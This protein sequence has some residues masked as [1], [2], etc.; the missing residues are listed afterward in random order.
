MGDILYLGGRS[1]F[2]PDPYIVSA[3]DIIQ[4][5]QSGKPADVGIVGIPFDGGVVSHRLGARFGPQAVREDLREYT[6]YNSDLDV[7]IRDLHIVDCGDIEIAITDFEETHRRVEAVLTQLF[8][9]GMTLLI[10]GGDHSLSAPCVRGLCN[11][12]NGRQIGVIDFDAHHD[13]RS[14][15]GRN[16]GLWVR[17][18]QEDPR[19]PVRGT[20][21]VQIGIRGFSYSEYYRDAVRA[22]GITVFRP[23]DVRTRGIEAVMAEALERA[24]AG[25]DAIYV[26]V[27]IDALDPPWAPG[28]NSPVHGGLM[29]WEVVAGVVLAGRHPLTRALDIMEIAPPLDV[30]RV[31]STL[32][33]EIAMQFLSALAL[34]RKE[35]RSYS[36]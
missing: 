17:E 8:E 22:M 29:P 10:L 21:I 35:A 13:V 9:T 2:F 7:D 11:A 20:N 33:A 4:P 18:I 26:S 34:R 15:W 5:F 36:K 32:G 23:V 25:T 24:S 3:A 28:T 30:N 19:A 14:G 12:L 16:S 1:N 27:D 31:T 6:T